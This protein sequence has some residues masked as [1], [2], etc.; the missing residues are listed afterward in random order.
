MSTLALHDS[1][2]RGG[3]LA[4]RAL[5]RALVASLWLLAGRSALAAVPAGGQ[6]LDDVRVES[7][8]QGAVIHVELA[9]PVRVIRHAPAEQG[10]V[11]RLWVIPTDAGREQGVAA[12]RES[13]RWQE[14]GE[15]PLQEVL[16]EYGTAG[17][18]LVLRF[19]RPVRFR[20]K[21]G[22]DFRSVD[23]QLLDGT[24]GDSATAPMAMPVPAA[25]GK[26]SCDVLLGRN[27][28][29]SELL[30]GA[31]RCVVQEDWAAVLGLYGKLLQ[32]PDTAYQAEA[33]E[34][35][36]LARER[37]GQPFRAKSEYEKYLSI[38]PKGEGAVR[39]RQRLDALE[40]A[41]AQP[42]PKL[43]PVS[44]DEGRNSWETFG[45]FSQYYFR[46]AL[47]SDRQGEVAQ[48]SLFLTNLDVTSRLRTPRFDVRGQFDARYRQNFLPVTFNENDQFRVS[49]A[50]VD[51][52][53]RQ[54]GL[55]GR[56]GR[57]SRASGGVMGRFDG[58][59]VSYRFNPQWQAT[60]VG[61]FPV[62]PYRSTAPDWD[63]SF[64]GI[65][66]EYGPFADY[67]AGNVFFINQVASGR[68]DRRAVGGEFRYQ[69]P[70]HPVFT[71]LDYDVYFNALNTAQVMANWNFDNGAI[72]TFTADYRKTPYL[73]T[74]NVV[75]GSGAD[76]LQDA[77]FRQS[78]YNLA[79]IAEDN[80]ATFKTASVGGIMPLTPRLQVNGDVTVTD[81]S[82]TKGSPWVTPYQG[83]GVQV[84]YAGQLIASSLFQEGD[85]WNF[86]L[87]YS[88][89]QINDYISLFVDGR[90]PV[91]P[92]IRL[93]PRLR[94]DYFT[95]FDGP[96][97]WRV[98]PG[99]RF[100]YRVAG[101]LNLELEGGFE[102][103][104]QPVFK[105]ERDTTGYYISAGYRW[106]F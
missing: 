31:R 97:V 38:Y 43:K 100:N 70:V 20:L 29:P 45:S 105:D 76:S 61:G 67:F 68:T 22:Q 46:E 63:K 51:I 82:A 79:A 57:Q 3:L 66:L 80:T 106:D 62:R 99:L 87:R 88:T 19:S 78:D 34:M 83:S 13:R 1:A 50:F 73:S 36:G 18:Q 91:T 64:A 37:S 42:Q 26:K 16:Y 33:L 58:G 101:K 27:P 2:H 35:V 41:G 47:I 44:V 53:D 93:D 9:S 71:L 69:H 28:P 25:K 32:Q 40:S 24:A 23:V 56:L 49:N 7:G 39:V 96:S 89:Q 30:E 5:L 48:Q 95:S 60:V 92:D 94:V 75:I 81:L 84:S 10:D 98:R 15:V 72:V 11:L 65:S 21:P 74:S 52:A 8:E 4:G 85:I 55:S 103:A 12:P 102:Y 6:M 90:H 54:L 86:G 77:L 14:S 17:E 59:V 104:N